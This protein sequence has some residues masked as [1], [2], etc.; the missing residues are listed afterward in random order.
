MA[1]RGKITRSL[2][3]SLRCQQ[4]ECRRSIFGSLPMMFKTVGCDYASKR[5]AK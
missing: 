2:A 5:F 1:V 4:S 3:R